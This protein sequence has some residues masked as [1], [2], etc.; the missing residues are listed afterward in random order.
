MWRLPPQLVEYIRFLDLETVMETAVTERELHFLLEIHD[1]VAWIALDGSLNC[2]AIN[3]SYVST[4]GFTDS[5]KYSVPFDPWRRAVE[6]NSH[7]EKLVAHP[8]AIFDGHPLGYTTEEFDD[9]HG[10][11]N[12]PTY[13]AVTPLELIV[14]D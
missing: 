1:N 6:Y 10:I 2:H 5:G 4:A 7:A 12:K 9:T 8:R 13:P 11:E 3:P 14:R